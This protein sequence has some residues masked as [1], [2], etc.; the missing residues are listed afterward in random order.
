MVDAIAAGFRAADPKN[1]ETYRRNAEAY[2][3]RL[4]ELDGEFQCLVEKSACRTL[5]FGGRFA[6][7]YFLRHYGLN[8]VTAYDGENEPGIRRIAE[9]VRYI[10]EHGVRYLFHD[11]FAR[12]KVARSIAEQT[13]AGLLLFHTAHNVTR[14]ELEKGVTFLDLMRANRDA[15]A[16]ALAP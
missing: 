9:V 10:K 4:A 14:E 2:K 5:V 12:P 3:A 11:E 1:A 16:L 7:R 6:C 13:G 15:L 8:G